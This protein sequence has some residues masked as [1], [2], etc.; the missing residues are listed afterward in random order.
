MVKKY[1]M[2]SFERLEEK[3]AKPVTKF[4]GQPDWLEEP[5]WPVSEEYEDRLM[6]FV[7]QIV[8]DKG[9][10]GNAEYRI[11]YVFLTHPENEDDD[12]FDLHMGEWG[13]GKHAVIIQ[14]DGEH[15]CETKNVKEGPCLFDED[16]NHYEYIPILE[17]GHDPDF[18]NQKDFL[19]M[20]DPEQNKYVDQIYGNK[21][22]GVPL[23]F[24]GDEWP[25]GDWKFL[26]QMSG[27]KLPFVL[28]LGNKGQLYA[29]ITS[30][31]KQ[32]GVLIQQG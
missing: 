9:M 20:K 8:L 10:L 11:A 15:T 16:G 31:F 4:G 14:P 21:I 28:D 3:P 12:V 24:K 29:F 32:G 5:Q 23:F 18:I 27:W 19:K 7:G 1:Q 2:T 30:D 6:T 22:G 13:S 17:E 26:L 25:E